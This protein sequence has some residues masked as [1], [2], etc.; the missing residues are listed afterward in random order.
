MGLLH[1]CERALKK[2]AKA[3]LQRCLIQCR[4]FVSHVFG[5]AR[6]LCAKAVKASYAG[7]AKDIACAIRGVSW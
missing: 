3:T 1:A 4:N 5:G 2:L 6:M 7:S